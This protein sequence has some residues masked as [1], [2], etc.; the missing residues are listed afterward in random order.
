MSR[1]IFIA[2]VYEYDPILVPALQ[3]QGHE[4]WQ[5]LL[6]HDGP[7]RQGLSERLRKLAD[8][9]VRYYETAERINDWGHS[10]RALA[11]ENIAEEPIEGDYVV[12]TNGDNYYCPGFTEQMLAAFDDDAVGVYCRMSHSHRRW[13]LVESRLDFQFIDCGCV[14]TRRS[15]VL[16]VGWQSRA[17]EADWVFISDLVARYGQARFRKLETVLFVHN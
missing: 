6:V 14:M 5:L 16:E 4:D 3:L 13:A 15:A 17:F 12:I 10:L 7:N 11:L 9:R 1:V 2:P 8:P